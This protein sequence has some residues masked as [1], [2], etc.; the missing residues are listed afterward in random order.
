M[1]TVLGM[2]QVDVGSI[3]MDV[4]EGY[5][6]T[7]SGKIH[8]ADGRFAL[9]TTIQI[10]GSDGEPINTEYE[11]HTNHT[12]MFAET[13]CNENGD[14]LLDHYELTSYQGTKFPHIGT[15]FIQLMMFFSQ[16]PTHRVNLYDGA[17]TDNLDDHKYIKDITLSYIISQR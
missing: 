4:G 6:R 8:Y 2:Q 13:P 10:V 5:N 15:H 12:I 7:Y 16:E 14:M 11:D 3:F 17:L 1:S 9:Y